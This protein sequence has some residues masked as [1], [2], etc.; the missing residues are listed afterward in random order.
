MA[1]EL[2]WSKRAKKSFDNIVD[3]IE[4]NCSEKSAKKFV[5]KAEHTL[6]S[7]SQN[8]KMFIEIDKKNIHKGIITKQTSVFYRIYNQHI[9]IITFWDNRRNPDNLKI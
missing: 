3:F 1:V 5:R 8:P 4:E 6:T 2:K 9:R 7:I